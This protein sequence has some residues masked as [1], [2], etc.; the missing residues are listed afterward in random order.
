MPPYDEEETPPEEVEEPETP[1]QEEKKEEITKEE[2]LENAKN[3]ARTSK[4]IEK[5]EEENKELKKK[6]VL[7][8]LMPEPPPVWPEPPKAP[9]APT[10]NVVPNAQQYPG[11]TQNQIDDTFKNLV[12]ANG[13]V[14]TGLLIDTLKDLMIK[15]QRAEERA[16]A[17]EQKTAQ[18]G[19]SFDDFQRNEIMREVHAKYPTLNPEN[20]ND[21]GGFE[22]RLWKFVRNEVVDQMMKMDGKPINVMAAADEAW[23]LFHG[24]DMKKEEKKKME[25]AELA[26]RNINAMGGTQ[27]N[28]PSS[29]FGDHEALVKATQ[30]GKKG[31][32]AERL[33]LAGQ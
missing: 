6:N 20:P 4:Y 24:N 29:T 18:I 21:N 25:E 14:D 33:R 15:N 30:Q 2:A 5:L 1:P 17:A 32:L 19:K 13:Y 31:A 11:V 16:K 12:D 10:I 7:D 23:Q 9:E 27:A 22:E 28:Q 3:P 8:S 26:K